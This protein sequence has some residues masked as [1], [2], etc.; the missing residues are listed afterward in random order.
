MRLTGNHAHAGEHLIHLAPFDGECKHSAKH[1]EFS[2]DAGYFQAGVLPAADV[3]GYFFGGNCVEASIREQAVLH[4]ARD[5]VFVIRERLGLGSERG[6]AERKEVTLGEFLQRGCRAVVTDASLTF[7]EARF[8]R[9]FD[10]FGNPL[11]GDR[12]STR[13]NSS[14]LGISYA[15]FCLKKKKKNIKSKKDISQY[16]QVESCNDVYDMG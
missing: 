13:L 3:P 9:G 5:P 4:Q 12:K 7:C 16:H 15:V 10:L 2:I 6:P 8:V 11:V 1:L 14:H